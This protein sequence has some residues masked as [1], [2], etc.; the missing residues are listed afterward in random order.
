MERVIDKFILYIS[1]AYLLFQTMTGVPLIIAVYMTLAAT[2]AELWLI[3]QSQFSLQKGELSD[4]KHPE[5][6]NI[7]LNGYGVKWII[8]IVILDFGAIA[9][10]LQ[11]NLFGILPLIVYD[12][13]LCRHYF[14]LGIAGI[15][16]IST[17]IKAF[18]NETPSCFVCGVTVVTLFLS[19]WLFRKTVRILSDEKKILRLRDDDEEQRQMLNHQNEQLL[20]ARD[21]EVETAQLAERN[22]I[23]REIHDNVGHTLSRALLQVGA[24]LAIHKEEPVHSEL[25]GVRETLDNAM[26]SIRASVHDLHDSSIDLSGTIRQMLEPLKDEFQIKVDL[27]TSPDMPREIKYGIIGIV[28]ECI[29]NILRHSRNDTVQVSLIEHP[30]FYQLVVHDYLSEEGERRACP[31]AGKESGTPGIGLTNMETR[32][33]NLGG[34][35]R[36]SEEN[37][38]RVFVSI[39]KTR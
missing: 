9:V 36:I 15:S 17:V 37:G 6:G 31:V 1:A 12:L 8:A 38:Y 29:S 4:F 27:D 25:S 23:A 5:V 30:A 7:S 21:S 39:P 22:R 32:A 11:N 24:L 14:G 26:N 34:T 13:L 18:Q 2:T 20:M 16:F 35:V 10:L 19:I 28:R 33:R 3:P